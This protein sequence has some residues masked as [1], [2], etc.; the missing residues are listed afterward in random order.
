MSDKKLIEDVIDQEGENKLVVSDTIDANVRQ[1]QGRNVEV[2][3]NTHLKKID[4]VVPKGSECY[5]I[6][7]NPMQ[8]GGN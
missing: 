3:E 1:D 7:K 6:K 5:I 2:E 4:C 8:K